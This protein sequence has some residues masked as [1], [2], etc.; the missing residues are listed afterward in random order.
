MILSF[1]L[2]ALVIILEAGPVYTIFMADVLGKNLTALKILWAV[3]SFAL[4]I[5]LCLLATFYPIHLGR[6]RLTVK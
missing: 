6:K 2:I 3:L 1:G 4:A 5:F